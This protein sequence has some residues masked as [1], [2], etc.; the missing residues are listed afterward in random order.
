MEPWIG[1]P[2][3]LSP[4]RGPS[5]AVLD[6]Q[7]AVIWLQGEIRP[8]HGRRALPRRCLA[9]QRVTEV[10]LDVSGMTFCDGTLTDFID[11][12][13]EHRTVWLR[14]PAPLVTDF[15]RVVGLGDR[16][17][18]RHPPGDSAR[19]SAGSVHMSDEERRPHRP[20]ASPPQGAPAPLDVATDVGAGHQPVS[21]PADPACWR[22]RVP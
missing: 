9:P 12:L 7:E 19:S 2:A 10:V 8:G 20:A 21:G 4:D 22:S 18:P 13:L 6:G 11:A 5:Q 17:V 16:L 3:P 15:L 1:Q 14:Q